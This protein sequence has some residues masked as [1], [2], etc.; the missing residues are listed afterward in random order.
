MK[1]IKVK[2]IDMMDMVAIDIGYDKY[3]RDRIGMSDKGNHI[4]GKAKNRWYK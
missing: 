1:R 4:S 2:M 3:D